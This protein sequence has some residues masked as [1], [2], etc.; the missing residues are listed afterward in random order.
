MAGLALVPSLALVAFT[1]WAESRVT[2]DRLIEGDGPGRIDASH[3]RTMLNALK[4]REG[5]AECGFR[6]HSAALAFAHLDPATKYRTRSGRVVEP[7]DMASASGDGLTRYAWATIV[8]EVN[9]CRVLCHNCHAIETADARTLA[10]SG[11]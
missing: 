4:I 11:R 9:Q 5:C 3:A 1:L 8:A 10:A 6:G 2:R 7:S